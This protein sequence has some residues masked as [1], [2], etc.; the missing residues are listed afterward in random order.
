MLIP[1]LEPVMAL[2]NPQVSGLVLSCGL[3]CSIS[4]LPSCPNPSPDPSA[5]ASPIPG[6]S[7]LLDYEPPKG[8]GVLVTAVSQLCLAWGQAQ[9]MDSVNMC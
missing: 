9:G 3:Q 8:R 7:L 6:L 4:T 2:H 5:C 1:C